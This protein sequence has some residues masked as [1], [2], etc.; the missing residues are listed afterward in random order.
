[1]CLVIE[2]RWRIGIHPEIR[3]LM[4]DKKKKPRRRKFFKFKPIYL[5]PLDPGVLIG[6]GEAQQEYSPPLGTEIG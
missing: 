5:L 6:H 4:K 2:V 3:M 1:M